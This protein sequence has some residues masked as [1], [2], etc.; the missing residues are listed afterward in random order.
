[1][2]YERHNCGDLVG[3]G[4]D[5]VYASWVDRNDSVGDHNPMVEVGMAKKRKAIDPAEP[6]PC[7]DCGDPA[8]HSIFGLEGHFW[9]QIPLC[10][11]CRLKVK[12]CGEPPKYVRVM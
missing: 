7:R 8:A 5:N 11:A 6:S 12:M 10:S 2:L 3:A 4:D 1:M 9:V